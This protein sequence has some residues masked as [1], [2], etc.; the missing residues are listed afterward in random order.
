MYRAK[1]NKHQNLEEL[2]I[3]SQILCGDNKLI[4]GEMLLGRATENQSNSELSMSKF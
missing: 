3:D 2:K 4:Y 1:C